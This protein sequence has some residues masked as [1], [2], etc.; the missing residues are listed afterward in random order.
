M[1]RLYLVF[2]KRIYDFLY[3]YTKN[4]DTAMDL[5]QDTFLS[6]FKTYAGKDLSEEKAGM[7]LYRIARNRSINYAKKFSTVRETVS[8]TEDRS[9]A[10]GGFEKRLELLDLE[11]KLGECLDQL[12]PSEKEIIILR[13]VEGLNLTAI[14]EIMEI[15]VSTASR[16]VIRA[17]SNLIEL[18]EKNGIGLD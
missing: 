7:L 14:A 2:R 5:T 9:Y 4:S 16:L 13:F 18:A 3:K 1:E 17:T 8:Y 11:S 6:F 10:S 12:D 15:S